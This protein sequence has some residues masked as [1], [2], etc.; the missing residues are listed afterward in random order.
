[1][2]KLHIVNQQ[3]VVIY[4]VEIDQ[5]SPGETFFWENNKCF[6][7]HKKS[8]GIFFLEFT[9]KTITSRGIL[10]VLNNSPG[11]IPKIF[12]SSR[13]FLNFRLNGSLFGNVKIFGFSGNFPG[14]FPY[15]FSP[16]L[17][18]RDFFAAH[19][20]DDFQAN[21]TVFLNVKSDSREILNLL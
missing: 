1:M 6:P 7:I 8:S 4:H 16:F 21:I 5:N 17:K 11:N 15:Y 12:L 19:H 20:C 3:R 18:F 14:K 13:N 10:N 9:V 2:L